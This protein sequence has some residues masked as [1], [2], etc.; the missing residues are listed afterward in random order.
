MPPTLLTD[1]R[2]EATLPELDLAWSAIPGQGLV[3]VF[4]TGTFNKGVALVVK[5]AE[6]AEKRNHHPDV[7]LTH[8]EVEVTLLTHSAG[9]V[10]NLDVEMAKAIDQEL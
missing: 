4:T 9:G 6:I 3:R 1:E 8:D 7:H 10:T 5:L 2:L